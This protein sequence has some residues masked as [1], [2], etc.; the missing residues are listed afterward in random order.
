MISKLQ[1]CSI[2]QLTQLDEQ[3]SQEE[4]TL[5]EE[6]ENVMNDFNL[7]ESQC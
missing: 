2:R 1:T 5:Q 3:L 4:V 7:D 6:R